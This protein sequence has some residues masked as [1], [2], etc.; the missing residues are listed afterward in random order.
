L[1]IAIFRCHNKY[2]RQIISV[3]V[4]DKGDLRGDGAIVSLGNIVRII[5][6]KDTQCSSN[7]KTSQMW[8]ALSIQY[9]GVSVLALYIRSHFTKTTS[10]E[11]YLYDV[12]VF[13]IDKKF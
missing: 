10:A 11:R 1:C 3:V 4:D 2:V 13:L 9:Y 6:Q 8:G 12:E 7:A 5:R